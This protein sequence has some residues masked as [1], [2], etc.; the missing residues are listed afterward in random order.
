MPLTRSR[1]LRRIALAASLV[2]VTA[3]AGSAVAAQP[4]SVWV[5]P[6]SGI[7]E[8][9]GADVAPDGSIYSLTSGKST[10]DGNMT[11]GTTTFTPASASDGSMALAKQNADGS[12]AWV[13]GSATSPNAW[14]LTALPDGSALVAGF[15]YNASYPGTVGSNTVPAQGSFAAKFSSA[16]AISWFATATPVTYGGSDNVNLNGV[17]AVPGGAG[18]SVVGGYLSPGMT[19]DLLPAISPI[20]VA[21]GSGNTAFLAGLNASGSWTWL[22]TS[23]AGDSG[24]NGVRALPDGSA[25]VSGFLAGSARFGST[26]LTGNGVFFA[27]GSAAGWQWAAQAQY[28]EGDY[29]KG[30]S[31]NFALGADGSVYF[32]DSFTG[33]ATFG[34]G[35]G[36]ISLTSTGG[37]RDIFVAKVNAN[38]TWA[39]ATKAGGAGQDVSYS[40]AVPPGVC[41]P[42]V[43]GLYAN[44]AQFGSLS[45]NSGN[46]MENFLATISAADGTWQSA[47][48]VAKA[49]SVWKQGP[50]VALADGSMIVQGSAASPT[51][52]GT[53]PVAS[54]NYYSGKMLQAPCAAPQNVKATAGD[55]KATISWDAVPGGSVTSYTVTA[56]PGGKSC[57]ATAPAT[58]CV[59]EGL[60]NGTTYTFKVVAVNAAGSG[61]ESAEA[62]ITPAAN[63][64]AA[65]EAN[66]KITIPAA[67][68][69]RG[70]T[71]TSTVNP[72]VGGSVRVTATLAGRTACTVTRKATKAGRMKV[73]CT[74]NAR[75]R[76]IIKKKAVTLKVT[77]RLTD[78]KGKTATASRNVRV[79][80]Y[81]VRT[82][83]TG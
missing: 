8:A 50:L 34:T 47:Y 44:S 25:I 66:P 57:T 12:W 22:L 71:L 19:A 51:T 38:G 29:P 83:V 55:G 49:A 6:A 74:L 39:W 68:V 23:D 14:G 53:L 28:T 67:V 3:G 80:R 37:S 65:A 75:T 62:K 69:T 63:A 30:T 61:P 9:W 27:K 35:A 11:F 59:I 15:R 10:A 78:A 17:S 64:Q 42:V 41:S 4:A 45:L 43:T 79:A 81:V 16:G 32:T 18:A 46:A 76:A 82:P 73:T 52:F 60:T 1:A 40:V 21:G 31:R 2:G 33:T 20:T 36:A 77:A 13:W 48:D 58:S 56:S 26:T 72:S 54:G 5:S 70:R 7:W 24:G